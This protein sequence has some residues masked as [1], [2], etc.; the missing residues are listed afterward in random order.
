MKSWL[1]NSSFHPN[2]T[3]VQ[4]PTSVLALAAFSCVITLEGNQIKG[5]FWWKDL[6]KGHFS[7]WSYQ[8]TQNL[9]QWTSSQQI[10]FSNLI[11]RWWWIRMEKWA[12]ASQGQVLGWGYQRISVKDWQTGKKSTLGG[13]K[14]FSV[15]S[16]RWQS[17][18]AN[19]SFG[20][21]CNLSSSHRIHLLLGAEAQLSSETHRKTA[22]TSPCVPAGNR[23]RKAFHLKYMKVSWLT[24]LALLINSA[25][26]FLLKSAQGNHQEGK[27]KKKWALSWHIQLLEQF[28]HF[29]KKVQ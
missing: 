5:P 23:H 1:S 27:L 25:L 2:P 6:P 19:I 3:A 13:G 12:G 21:I 4:V 28:Q 14:L 29:L 22:S 26:F 24:A 18:R 7:S 17:S 15:G 8:H 10:C 20:Y 16:G 9:N 11:T